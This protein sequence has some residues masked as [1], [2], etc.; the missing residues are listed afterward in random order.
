MKHILIFFPFLLLYS[1]LFFSILI[2]FTLSYCTTT[3]EALETEQEI[4]ANKKIILD[5]LS[6]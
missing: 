2:M 1:P 5:K 3:E 4:Q 6:A